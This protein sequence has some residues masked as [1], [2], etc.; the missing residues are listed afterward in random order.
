VNE[1]ITLIAA[2]LGV[3]ADALAKAVAALQTPATQVEETCTAIARSTGKRCTLKAQAGS[4]VCHL[5][6]HGAAKAPAQVTQVVAREATAKVTVGFRA[7]GSLARR[8]AYTVAEALGLDA[9]SHTT[10]K[11]LLAMTEDE[12]GALL[13]SRGYAMH[14]VA[15]SQLG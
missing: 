1:L 13:A 8:S 4:A 6:Q 7:N 3:D 9:K 10:R 14:R 12:V 15:A 2:T 11:D 5:P